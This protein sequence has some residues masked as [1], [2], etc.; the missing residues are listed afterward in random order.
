MVKLAWP[1][2]RQK[3]ND[4]VMRS[5]MRAIFRSRRRLIHF[6][7]NRPLSS[8][9]R[10]VFSGHCDRRSRSWSRRTSTT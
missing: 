4:S 5:L 1:S 3:S 2:F 6:I 7:S 10:M 8:S 9:C